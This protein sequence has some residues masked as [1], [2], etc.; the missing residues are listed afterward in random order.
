MGYGDYFQD[1][2]A[3]GIMDDHY[4]IN[5]LIGIPTIDIINRPVGEHESGFGHYHHTHKDD[6]GIIDKRTLK[7]VGQVVTAVIYNESSGRF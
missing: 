2:D 7:V 5:Q 1:F 6:I 4:Y 3:G